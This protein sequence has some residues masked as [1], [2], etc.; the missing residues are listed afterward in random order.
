MANT[1][2]ATDG[3]AGASFSRRTT[4]PE[5]AL[6]AVLDG[7]KGTVHVY[8]LATEA[9]TGTCTVNTSTYAL[10]DTGG[11]YTADTAFAS[12]EYGW[13]RRTAGEIT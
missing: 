10:T 5:F 9:V 11:N 6:G 3:A 8:V 2:F 13:V 1:Y 4:S 12:G 7:N